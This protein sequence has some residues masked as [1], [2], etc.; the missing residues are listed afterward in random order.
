MN[1][2]VYIANNRPVTDSLTVAETFGKDHDKV[3]R[4]IRELECSE[5]F[6][7][8]NFGESTY[9]NDRGRIYPKFIMT[10]QGFAFLVMGYTGKEAARFKEMYIAEFTKM[11]NQLADPYAGLSQEVRAIFAVDTKVQKLETRIEEID[12]K[13][14]TWITLTQ[15]E[16]RRVQ[17]A[18][19]SRV[20][21]FS[22][23]DDRKR[24]FQELY[25]DIKDRWGVP[26]YRDILRKDMQDVIRYIA[27]WV[28]RKTA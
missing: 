9:T 3:L 17:R 15:G 20:Y 21:E 1:Q 24:M 11:R 6:S 2:L 8:S 28:P 13:V 27:A 12:E 19:G 22:S 26:S 18:V 10:E 23:D 4:D 25:R 7:L 16:Q 5:E 14:E